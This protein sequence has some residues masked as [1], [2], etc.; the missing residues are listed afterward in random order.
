MKVGEI[1]ECHCSPPACGVVYLPAILGALDGSS[2]SVLPD[3]IKC[4]KQ[5]VSNQLSPSPTRPPLPTHTTA[6]RTPPTRPPATWF[7]PPQPQPQPFPFPTWVPTVRTPATLPW[8]PPTFPVTPW[9]PSTRPPLTTPSRPPVRPSLPIPSIPPVR[10]PPTTP[11]RPPL[12]T[13]S[14]LSTQS[15]QP[16]PTSVSTESTGKVYYAYFYF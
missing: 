10:P 8:K 2:Q 13:R 5:D 4:I 15:S 11:S 16:I 6:T 7:P 9:K 3:E 1:L 14:T 12:T